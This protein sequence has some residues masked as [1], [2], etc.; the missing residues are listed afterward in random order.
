MSAVRLL[1]LNAKAYTSLVIHRSALMNQPFK[2]S[3]SYST[4]T[5]PPPPPPPS[6]SK[7]KNAKGKVFLN[8][9]SRAFTFSLSTVIVIGASGV[10]LLVVY[11]ILSELFL[12]SG[13]TKTF[14]KAVKLVE[15]NE[16]ARALMKLTS[17]E[18]IRAYGESVSGKW[19]RNRPVQS[20]RM[21]DQDGVDRLVMKFHVE[22][23]ACMHGTVSLEQIDQSFWSSEFAYIALDVPKKNRIYIIEPKFQAKNYVPKITRQSGF[24]GLKWGPKKD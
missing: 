18:R 4:K 24:L 11:L 19:V 22:S 6:P 20:V 21:R 2:H 16:Q 15:K 14:N 8:R 12:P 1:Q 7:D 17:G 5:S 3:R 9:I 10:A 23:D 13:D